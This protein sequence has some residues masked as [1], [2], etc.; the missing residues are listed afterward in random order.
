MTH[1][2]KSHIRD[3]LLKRWLRCCLVRLLL[4]EA[5]NLSRMK[6]GGLLSSHEI[7]LSEIEKKH[8]AEQ[9]LLFQILAEIESDL[10][11]MALLL[12]IML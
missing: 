10:G 2:I 6:Q 11:D 8:A 3:K 7:V 1:G 12:Q 5:L 9:E 4:D